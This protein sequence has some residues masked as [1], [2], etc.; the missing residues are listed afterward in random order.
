VASGPWGGRS[1]L[2]SSERCEIIA[3]DGGFLSAGFSELFFF[4]GSALAT[5]D[6]NGEH[7]VEEK[8]K[9][10]GCNVIEVLSATAAAPRCRQN[11]HHEPRLGHSGTQSERESTCRTFFGSF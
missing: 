5:G 9:R 11:I 4:G 2:F 7:S 3:V 6:Q 1:A 8:E 10:R